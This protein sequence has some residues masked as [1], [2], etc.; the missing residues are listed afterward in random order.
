MTRAAR[1][2]DPHASVGRRCGALLESLARVR[3]GRR[4]IADR[5]GR[6][7]GS[8]RRRSA[9]RPCPDRLRGPRRTIAPQ[10]RPRPGRGAQRRLARGVGATGSRS[11]TTTCCV[12]P[13]LAGRSGRR[14]RRPRP[15]SSAAARAGSPCRCRPTAARPTG[16]AAPPAWP[17]SRWITADMRLPARGARRGAAAST[18]GSR[19]RSAR[20]PTSRCACRTRGCRL[21]RGRRRTMHP[22]RPA[23]WDASAAPAA[24]QRRRRADARAAR[25][26][27]ALAAPARRAGAVRAHLAIDRGRSAAA[28]C[29]RGA[30]AARR[31]GC[32]RPLWAGLTAE[33]AGRRIA[34]GPRTCARSPRM[35][36]TSAS[37]P[38]AATWHWLRGRSP[39]ARARPWRAGA[40]AGRRRCCSTATARSSTTSP[41]TAIRRWSSPLPGAAEALRRLRASRR[42]GSASSRNQSGIARGLLTAAAGRRGQP[43]GRRAARPVRH[44]AGLPARRRPTAARCRKPRPGMI[45]RP[46]AALG[47]ARPTLR[48]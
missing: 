1:R 8:D 9:R 4:P 45:T 42:R 47:V 27:L 35:L 28:G 41:T 15:G 38:P 13:T 5:A 30:P 48:R 20:T 25:P 17:T 33:F 21:V 43:P 2:R 3:P 16:S 34:P 23:R 12:S 32:R 44:L 36:A 6:T 11:S 18:S 39:R 22:V 37:I 40:A 26:R 29:A 24:R 19:A 46:R 7:T 31:R 14:P 10:R